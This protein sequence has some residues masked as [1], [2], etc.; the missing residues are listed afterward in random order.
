[1]LLR[2]SILV[3]LAACTRSSDEPVGDDGPQMRLGM[4]DAL[5]ALAL[6]ALDYSHL[7]EAADLGFGI[8]RPHR[9][10]GHVSR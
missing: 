4:C 9:F 8:V 1:M 2:A 7:D 5:D 3:V 6:D 10:T